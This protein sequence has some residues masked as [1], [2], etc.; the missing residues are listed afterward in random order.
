MQ[1][2]HLV[3]FVLLVNIQMLIQNFVLT[4]HLVNFPAQGL[5]LAV[6]VLLENSQ[7]QKQGLVALVQ[8]GLIHFK[9][10]DRVLFVQLALFLR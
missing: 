1:K 9:K 6:F 3:V 5:L 7:K 2:L 8:Q 10:L 4:V